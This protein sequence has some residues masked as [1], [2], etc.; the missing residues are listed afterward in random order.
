VAFADIWNEV[1]GC[2]PRIDPIYAQT[3]VNRAWSEIKDERLWSF[4][5]AVGVMQ[6]PQI[7][8]AGTVA[9]TQYST[10]VQLD[11]V[12]F[13]ALNNI[14][15][16]ILTLRQFRCGLGGGTIYNIAAQNPN[17]QQITLDRIYQEPSASGQP[18]QVYRCYFTPCDLNGAYT[19]DFVRWTVVV[20]PGSGYS[21]VGPNLD[22]TQ[23]EIDARDPQRSAQDLAYVMSTR[24][25]DSN[26]MPIYELWPHP[27]S[28]QAYVGMY[29]RRGTDLS[30]NSP[31]LPMTIKS[32]MVA[33]RAKGLAYDWAIANAGR[34]PE[35]KG[36]EWALLKSENQ[37]KYEKALNQA[38]L[39]DDELLTENYLPQLRDYLA[40]PP[41]DSDYFQDHDVSSWFEG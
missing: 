21:I 38:M 6:A 11:P 23:Q 18:Y 17:L 25:I 33:E 2:I 39:K 30:A 16:P 31:N 5:R 12:A 35:L 20:N 29:R 34:F 9:V 41:I 13:A 22:L 7:I 32:H 27:T 14:N 37:R 28:Q 1:V 10:T 26:S 19:T 4:L 15:N 8:T 3:L 36:I 40:Y 24:N